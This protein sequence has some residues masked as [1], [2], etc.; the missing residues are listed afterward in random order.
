MKTLRALTVLA[1]L[2][3]A[4]AEAQ[5]VYSAPTPAQATANPRSA[6]QLEQLVAPVALYPDALLAIIFP[7][8]TAST[9]LVLAARH[10]R[11]RP[12]DAAG[13]ELQSWDESVKS[14][15]AY[16]EVLLWMDDNLDWTKQLG[17]SFAAQPAGVMQATQRL[18]A[19]AAANGVLVDTPQQSVIREADIVRIVPTQPTVIYVPSYQPDI[20]L[21]P[22]TSWLARP[23]LGFSAGVAVGSWL[24]F[25]CDWRRQTIWVGNRHRPWTGHDW[26]RP[27]LVAPVSVVSGPSRV[28][29]VRPWRPSPRS[30][31]PPRNVVVEV[32][33]PRPLVVETTRPGRYPETRSAGPRDP[34]ADS[35]APRPATP[36]NA[37]PPNRSALPAAR[38]VPTPA[39]PP[40][41]Q[42]P[43]R[44]SPPT[45]S[46]PAPVAPPSA[47]T[48]PP[49]RPADQA[50]RSRSPRSE[51]PESRPP[52]NPAPSNPN[53]RFSPPPPAT[54]TPPARTAPAVTTPAAG[55]SRSTPPAQAPAPA[56]TAPTESTP[57]TT[58]TTTTPPA[59]NEGSRTR[60]R[61]E[62]N[63]P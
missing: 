33:R 26:R 21:L 47:V 31:P 25:E 3:G 23:Y 34:R 48:T 6:E 20:L 30:T 18:R 32:I 62:L 10:L 43:T 37:T 17:D 14:L 56:K 29:E 57:A 50:P 63:A 61:R 16:P 38:P 59:R 27:L 13:V 11:E 9:D 55:S 4:V 52:A 39:T 5:P 40:T 22:P 41:G 51:R 19:R 15:A 44:F 24:A 7:A 53:V 28:A 49:E 35:P 45:S 42:P 60:D 8:A 12:Q 1:L 2:S 54:G 46:T 36:P 58:N